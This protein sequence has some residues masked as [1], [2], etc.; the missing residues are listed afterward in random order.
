MISIPDIL[1][2]GE[3]REDIRSKCDL[4]FRNKELIDKE[5]KWEFAMM[6]V[7]AALVFTGANREVNAEKLKECRKMLKKE[8]GFFSYLRAEMEPVVVSKLAMANDPQRYLDDLKSV[9]DKVK[10]GS[11]FD[12]GYMVQAAICI[13]DAERVND[14]D[15]IIAEYK[16]L[17]RK[18]SKEHPMIT[19]SEDIVFSILLVMTDKSVDTIL[20]E[21]NECYDYLKKELKIKVDSN[22]IQGL[23]E[24]LALSDGNMKEK[25]DKVVNLFNTF[26]EHGVKYGKSYNEFASLGSLIDLDVEP[27]VLVDE[28]AETA[29]YLKNGKGF[30]GM[31]MDKKQRLM[32]ASMLVGDAYNADQ[33]LTGN[34]TMT[35]AVAMVV[36]EEIALMICLMASVTTSTTSH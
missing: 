33:F 23:G 8:A 13:C 4:L 14:A 19:G 29:E 7:S 5:F 30:G 15:E 34:T 24:I 2:G 35:S 27:G 11:V 25:C 17:Y 10:R 9:Y 3:M 20:G 1:R 6:N 12:S 36:A 16:D 21:L 26:A 32:F 18:M 28:I 22:E 31:S